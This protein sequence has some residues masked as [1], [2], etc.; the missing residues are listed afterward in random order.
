MPDRYAPVALTVV[1]SS[2]TGAVSVMTSDGT[3]TACDVCGHPLET[4]DRIAERFCRATLE[5][6][7]ARKCICPPPDVPHVR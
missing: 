7:L 5:H 6:A 1:A 2:A 3:A 4:H